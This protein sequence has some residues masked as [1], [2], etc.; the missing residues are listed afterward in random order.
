MLT[1]LLPFIRITQRAP[2]R[3]RTPSLLEHADEC[4]ALDLPLVPMWRRTKVIAADCIAMATQL[5]CHNVGGKD[6]V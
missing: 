5:S 3:A 4:A 6:H 2:R 1:T